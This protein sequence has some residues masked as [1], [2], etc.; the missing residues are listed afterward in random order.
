MNYRTKILQKYSHDVASKPQR[1]HRNMILKP[2]KRLSP[3]SEIYI[4]ENDELLVICYLR[5]IT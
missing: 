3:A 2:E 1:L 5:N 4:K